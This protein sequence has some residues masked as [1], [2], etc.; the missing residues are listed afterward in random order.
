LSEEIKAMLHVR[1]DGLCRRDS[2]Q[3]REL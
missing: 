3:R 1:N 2:R